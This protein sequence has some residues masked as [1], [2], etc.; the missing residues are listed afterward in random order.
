MRLR[1]LSE[2]SAGRG[3]TLAQMAMAWVLRDSRV[4]T[5][6]VGASQWSQIDD[7]LGALNNLDFTDDELT[8]IDSHAVDGGIDLW[9][10]S[11]GQD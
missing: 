10:T 1:A 2:I 5:A 6:L 4:T 9:A 8:A 11:S 7:S 3:Q